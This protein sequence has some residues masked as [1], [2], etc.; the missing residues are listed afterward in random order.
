MGAESV[1]EI[2]AEAVIAAGAVVTR[3]VPERA[4]AIGAPARVRRTV[5][6]AA[7]L[8]VVAPEHA[9]DGLG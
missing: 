4:V 9:A 1:I 5:E 3:S 8:L 6:G 2:G 7:E